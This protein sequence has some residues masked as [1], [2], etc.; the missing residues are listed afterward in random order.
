ML[1]GFNIDVLD[2]SNASLINPPV[3]YDMMVNGSTHF[4]GSLLD[5]MHILKRVSEEYIV[6]LTDKK[7]YLSDHNSVKVILESK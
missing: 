3:T 2:F 4:D 6:I 5:H 1:G 7:I